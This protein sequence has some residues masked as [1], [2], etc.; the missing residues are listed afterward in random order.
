MA[1]PRL[2]AA[3]SEG[4]RPTP[5]TQ[6]KTLTGRLGCRRQMAQ[7][8]PKHLQGIISL[9]IAGNFASMGI[10][11]GQLFEIQLATVTT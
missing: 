7:Q 1:G 9:E 10:D 11:P 8:V 5:V 4:I 3:G 6:H 2:V